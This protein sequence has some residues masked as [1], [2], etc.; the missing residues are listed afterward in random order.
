MKKRKVPMRKCIACQQPKEKK[1]LFRIVRSPEG[2]VSLD[3]TG[4]KNGRGAY[5]SK[6]KECIEI[7][8]KKK[9]LSKHL[10]VE[11]DN[12]VFD[13]MYSY[14]GEQNSNV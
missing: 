8:Q 3:L 13:E 4:K 5:L 12:R 1:E 10:E 6:N 7:A 11:V 2:E 14:L 9:L